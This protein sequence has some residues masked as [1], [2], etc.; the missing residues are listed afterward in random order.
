[1]QIVVVAFSLGVC[2]NLL[3][4]SMATSDVED[5]L[6]ALAITLMLDINNCLH[7]VVFHVLVKVRSKTSC[8]YWQ[9]PPRS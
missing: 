9:L 8:L 4:V 3:E 6:L 7:F 2:R 5:A 1:M